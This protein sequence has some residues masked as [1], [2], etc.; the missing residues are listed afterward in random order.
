MSSSRWEYKV[1]GDGRARAEL[2]SESGMNE[3]VIRD[4]ELPEMATAGRASAA[5]KPEAVVV[6]DAAD[7]VLTQWSVGVAGGAFLF[8]CGFD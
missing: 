8:A 7:E 5:T 2:S 4:D 1:I 3:R 6:G